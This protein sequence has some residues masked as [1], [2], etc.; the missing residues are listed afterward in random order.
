MKV[1]SV[2]MITGAEVLSLQGEKCHPPE[3]RKNI[4]VETE[5]I[6]VAMGAKPTEPARNFS[7][8]VCPFMLSGTAQA[9]GT[10]PRP[11]KKDFRVA[12]GI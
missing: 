6:V 7:L 12:M 5:G 2:Q 10:S 3:G 1:L 4:E 8:A 9:C 11:F